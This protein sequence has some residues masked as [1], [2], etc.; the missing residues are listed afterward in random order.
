MRLDIP[1]ELPYRREVESE[2]PSP[3]TRKLPDN[4]ILHRL[5]SLEEHAADH[6]RTPPGRRRKPQQPSREVPHER[7]RSVA[8]TD[9]RRPPRTVTDGVGPDLRLEERQLLREAGR[10]RVVRRADLCEA[11]YS[12]KSRLLDTDLGYLRKQGLVEVQRVNLR[13]DA[14]QRTIEHIEVISLTKAGLSRLISQGELPKGQRGYAGLSRPR[15]IEHDSQI[16]RAY[17]KEAAKITEKG[18]TNLRVMLDFEIRSQVS[19]TI[20][21]ERNADAQSDLPYIKQKV[22]ERFALPFVDGTI[23]IPDARIEYALPRNT[24]Q[25]IDPG[26][27]TGYQDIEVLTAAYHGAHLRLKMQ[28]GFRNY[29]SRSHRATLTAKIEDD[30]HLIEHILEL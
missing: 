17:R 12:G 13:R 30:H 16:Y 4:P 29:A 15:Q 11:L 3:T 24:D 7:R 5:K 18:G 26:S 21:A 14:W 2:P 25:E 10:F 6:G 22:A 9:A 1:Q 20:N 27:R 23:Q 8:S 19:K 28:A